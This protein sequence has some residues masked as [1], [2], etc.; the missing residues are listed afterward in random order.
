[1]IDEALGKII[2]SSSSTR[3]RREMGSACEIFVGIKGRAGASFEIGDAADGSM[4][5]RDTRI[6]LL[7]LKAKSK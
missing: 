5:W 7:L 6:V 4:L 3:A 2:Y 1:M